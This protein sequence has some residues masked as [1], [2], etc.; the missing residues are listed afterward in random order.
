VERK[1]KTLPFGV[2]ETA[3]VVANCLSAAQ[4][5]EFGRRYI[6]LLVAETVAVV[7]NCLSAAQNDE[8]GRRYILL[9]VAED[10]IV[11]EET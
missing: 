8:F 5:D 4:N 11:E 6:L 9:L 1:P 3:A 2:A 7:A 10:G